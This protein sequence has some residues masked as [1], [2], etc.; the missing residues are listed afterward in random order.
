MYETNKISKNYKT[1]FMKRIFFILTIAFSLTS[2]S[3]FAADNEKISPAALESFKSSFKTA[4]EVNWSV[5]DTYYKANFALNGQYVSA[6]YDGEGTM[7]ALTRN[8]SSLNLPI[9][10]QASLRNTYEAYWISD[11]VEMA[12]EEGTSYYITLETADTKLVLKSTS[13]AE[14]SNYKKLRKS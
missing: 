9:A 13:N 2:L 6:Y 11:L 7:I 8:I 10:L 1:A 4:T 14:W 5:S 12:N 3:S